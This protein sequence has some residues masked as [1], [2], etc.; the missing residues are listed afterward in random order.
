MFQIYR[1]AFSFSDC[2]RQYLY[3]TNANIIYYDRQIATLARL[4]KH[5][6]YMKSDLIQGG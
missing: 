6:P 4:P 2:H 1:E 5:A 3:T